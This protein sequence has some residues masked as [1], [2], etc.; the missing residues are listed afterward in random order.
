M[1][2]KEY[3]VKIRFHSQQAG[4]NF[5][6]WLCESGEQEYWK[7]MECQDMEEA[8]ED[9]VVIFHYDGSDPLEVRTEVFKDF[10]VAIEESIK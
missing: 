2:D 4:D 9:G 5:V 6:S 3:T 7:Y 8:G 1:S 10:F